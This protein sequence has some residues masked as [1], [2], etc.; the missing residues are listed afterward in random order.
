MCTNVQTYKHLL[1]VLSAVVGVAMWCVCVCVCVCV[2]C[3]RAG[4]L[5][6]CVCVVCVCV[7]ACGGE[8]G[9]S[10]DFQRYKFSVG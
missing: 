8:G 2:C 7:C 5:C 3:V 9:N 1:F 4:V 10:G 6:A